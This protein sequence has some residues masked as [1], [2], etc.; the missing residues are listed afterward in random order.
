MA[1]IP[2]LPDFTKAPNIADLSAV[3]SAFLAQLGGVGPDGTVYPGNLDA[4]NLRAAPGFLNRQKREPYSEF[5]V[6]VDPLQEGLSTVGPFAFD[7]VLQGL[8][9]KWGTLKNLQAFIAGGQAVA[10]FTIK[11]VLTLSINGALLATYT[12]PDPAAYLRDN[13]GYDIPAAIWP[14]NGLIPAG[15]AL[16]LMVQ[17]INNQ[18]PSTGL[19][20]VAVPPDPNPDACYVSL[21]L[22]ALHRR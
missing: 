9:Y 21:F 10:G 16:S 11:A 7:V 8:S 3:A 19:I 13:T 22:K 15:T 4:T 1:L 18:T 12:V 2:P 20:P 5:A 6:G 17:Y 14:A